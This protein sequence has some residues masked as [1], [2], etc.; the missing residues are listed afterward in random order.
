[1]ELKRIVVATDLSSAAGE[2]VRLAADLAHRL[3][4]R[5]TLLHVMSGGQLERMARAPAPPRPLDAIVEQFHGVVPL[6]VR[7]NLTVGLQVA[8]G[9]AAEEIVRAARRREADLVVMGD[10][11]RKGVARLVR[12]SVPERVLREAPCPVLIVRF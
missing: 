3:G 2:S 4:A 10:D 11:G 12:R 5:L 7:A 1:M 8:V 6:A 9:S